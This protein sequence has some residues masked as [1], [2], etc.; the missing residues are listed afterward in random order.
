MGD[1]KDREFPTLVEALKDKQVRSRF[2][3][4]DAP[5]V[6]SFESIPLVAFP[7]SLSSSLA[8][9]WKMP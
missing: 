3:G 6:H 5:S 2:F 8:A 4:Y 7:A 1:T 9:S